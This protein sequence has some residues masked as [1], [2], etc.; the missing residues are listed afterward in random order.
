MILCHLHCW[1]CCWELP[2]DAAW[3]GV[4]YPAPQTKATIFHTT[5]QITCSS[6]CRSRGQDESW[7]IT[8][9]FASSTFQT[10]IRCRWSGSI[11]SKPAQLRHSPWLLRLQPQFSSPRIALSAGLIRSSFWNDLPSFLI[12]RSVSSRKSPNAGQDGESG[13]ESCENDWKSKTP[14]R[15]DSN[16]TVRRPAST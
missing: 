14:R 10:G 3:I 8:S 15:G 2:D 9:R 5:L 4:R 6:A 16:S 1:R 13:R 7:S 11:P 12:F